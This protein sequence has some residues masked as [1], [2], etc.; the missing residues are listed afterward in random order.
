VK[1]F[2]PAFT[3]MV[4]LCIGVAL[5][6]TYPERP[7]RL[8]VPSSPGIIS[9]V[10]ARIIAQK[11]SDRFGKQFFVENIPGGAM[12]IGMGAAARA[13]PDGQTILVA[14]STLMVNPMIHASVPYDAI[15]DFSPVTLLGVSHFVLVVNPEVP[16][17]NAQELIALIKE[18]P[19]KYNFTSGGLG[20]TPHLLGELLRLT[21]GLDLV[22]V[23]FN[24]GGPALNATLAGSTQIMFASPSIALQH[25]QQG[26]LRALA[27]TSKTRMPAFPEVPT[28]TEAGLPGEGADTIVGILVPAGTSAEIID[29]LHREISKIIA[30]PDVR[31]RAL[32]LGF[33]PVGSTPEEFG[34]YI[35]AEIER[36]GKLIRDANIRKE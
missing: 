12:N 20:T 26:K 31:E 10:L 16:A 19:R 18:N 23:P 8:I 34:S 21:F 25:V 24:G 35:K 27:V 17:K 7:V 2:C 1:T 32:A 11:L 36:W 4:V 29:V 28:L 30:M 6:D 33:Q 13:K 5:A 14:V 3:A 9:D 15:R 22:H